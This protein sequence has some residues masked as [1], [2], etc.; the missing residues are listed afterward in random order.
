MALS[1]IANLVLPLFFPGVFSPDMVFAPFGKR[2]SS[3]YSGFWGTQNAMSH[4]TRLY[5]LGIHLEPDYQ[6]ER[7]AFLSQNV[8]ELFVP[9]KISFP[10]RAPLPFLVMA[11]WTKIKG[12]WL[13]ASDIAIP[14]GN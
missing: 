2:D 14:V 8:A 10:D 3:D 13:L 7:I 4:F 9:A 11:F 1:R 12:N 6:K 5:V